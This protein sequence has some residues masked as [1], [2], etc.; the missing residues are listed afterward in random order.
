MRY[1]HAAVQKHIRNQQVS[2]LSVPSYC[3]RHGLNTWTFR[4]WKKRH[5][6]SSVA[7]PALPSFVKVDFPSSQYVEVV[8]A[9]KAVVRIPSGMDAAALRLVLDAIKRSRI[10]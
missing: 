10:V 8:T 7:T 1:P 3:R 2:G 4:D 5:P 6:Q 9:S